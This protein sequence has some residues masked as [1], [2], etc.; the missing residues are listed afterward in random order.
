MI[1]PFAIVFLAGLFCG[2]VGART[3][4]YRRACRDEEARRRWAFTFDPA[5]VIKFA[6]KR[7]Q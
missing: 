3:L 4:D 7:P 2:I 1:V 5:H 6:R